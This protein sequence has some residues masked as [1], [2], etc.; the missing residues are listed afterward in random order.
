[1][2]NDNSNNN[3]RAK[4]T[5]NSIP[6]DSTS[7]EEEMY[8]LG[9]KYCPNHNGSSPLM[10]Y[11]KEIDN[12]ICPECMYTFPKESK[13]QNPDQYHGRI[14]TRSGYR[15]AGGKR[16]TKI[17]QQE[18]DNSNNS[19]SSGVWIQPFEHNKDDRTLNNKGYELS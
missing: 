12:F 4:S 11:R 5:V 18:E 19:I 1:M 13:E 6:L 16:Y 9:Q 8:S 7:I 2:I 3:S 17:S 10:A 15:S 14:R